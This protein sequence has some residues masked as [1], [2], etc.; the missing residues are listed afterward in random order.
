MSVIGIDVGSTYTKY[1][2]MESGK[3]KELYSEK[4][5]IRQREHFERV[6]QG[7]KGKYPELEIVSCGYGKQ[8]ASEGKRMNELTA[9][10][11]GV[12]FVFPTAKVVLDIGGQDTKVI[13][14]EDGTLKKFFVNDKCAAGSGMFLSNTLRLLE[15]DFADVNLRGIKK[16]QITLASAC[17][18]FA[19]SEIVELLA[20]NVSPDEIIYA[21]IWHIVTQAKVPLSKVKIDEAG[22]LLSGGLTRIAGFKEFASVVLG[23]KCIGN[24]NGPYYSAIG[25]SC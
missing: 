3:I 6:W 16:P 11:R 2:I 8:N 13:V 15:Q 14:Q 19:Q 1:C 7:L 22:I 18:V 10:A 23:C 24:E 9:L 20:D 17:A 5:P 25:C 12:N 4:T 21:V